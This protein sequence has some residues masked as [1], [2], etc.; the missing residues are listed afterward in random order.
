[1]INLSEESWN[2]EIN[3]I[4]KLFTTKNFC[5]IFNKENDFGKYFPIKFVD[6]VKNEGFESRFFEY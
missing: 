1:M 3:K 4:K 2:L 6:E 5:A